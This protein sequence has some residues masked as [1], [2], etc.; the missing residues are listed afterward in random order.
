MYRLFS[1]PLS[2][3]TNCSNLLFNTAFHNRQLN[4]GFF[5]IANAFRALGRAIVAAATRN[6]GKGGTARATK[7]FSEGQKLNMKKPGESK[8]SRAE[9]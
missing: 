1:S 5:W 4:P 8:L 9:Q 3:P 6:A 2:R 7:F